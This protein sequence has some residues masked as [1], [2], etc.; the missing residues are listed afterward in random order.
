MALGSTTERMIVASMSNATAIAEAHLLE[1]D[2]V[3]AGEACEHRDDDQCGA[4]DDSSRRR[5]A[6]RHRLGRVAGLVVALSDP[7][8]Q[9]HLVVHREPEEHGE[10]E[11]RHPRLDRVRL[12]EAEQIGADTFLEDEHQQAVRGADREQVERHGR[13]GHHDRPEDDGEQHERQR[14]HERDHPRRGVDDRVEVVDVLRG[15]AADEDLGARPGERL[16][17]DLGAKLAHGRHRIVAGGVALDR[18]GEHGDGAVGGPSDLSLAEPRIGCQAG[19][20][21]GEGSRC[22]RAVGALRDDDLDRVGRRLREVPFEG[23]EALLRREAVGKR[24]DAA[25]SDVHAEDRR[26]EQ[27]QERDRQRQAQPRSAQDAPDDAAPEAALR[28]GGREQPLSDERDPESI[29][30]VPEQ[31]EQR[32]QQRRRSNNRDDPDRDRADGQAPHDRARHEQHPEHGDDERGAAEDHG[33]ARREPRDGDRV[34]LLAPLRALLAVSGDD[35]QGVV[36]PEREPHPRE[37]VDHEDGELEP[38]GE[39]RDEAEGDDDRDARHQNRDEARHDGSEDEQEDDERCRKA[40]LELAGLEI[41]LREQVEV[42]VECLVTGDGDG[43]RC[44]LVGARSGLHDRLGLVVVEDR[45]RDD[46]GVAVGGDERS[47]RG[48]EVRPRPRESRGGALVREAAHEALELGRVDGVALGAHDDDVRERG[49]RVRGER[50]RL[51]VDGALR[52]RIVR[53][54]ALGREAAPEQS[55]D[56]RDRSDGDCDP[57]ADRGPRMAC[58][59]RGERLRR[60]SHSVRP[61]PS[62]LRSVRPVAWGGARI[63]V[64]STPPTLDLGGRSPHRPMGLTCSPSRGGRYCGVAPG[65]TT[66]WS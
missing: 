35:E 42:V 40:E 37:H 56:R 17:R 45:D 24:R 7:A 2:E 50:A 18:D 55:D 25:R 8:E 26:G 46:R 63:A 4:R 32:R 58:A 39:Q 47:G 41:L 44:V 19:P 43:E 29:D 28:V 66:P 30:A 22:D 3:S 38:L 52:L 57:D 14:E 13:A 34:V 31:S 64:V 9:E 5:D 1:H 6:E 11:Q 62:G 59:Q 21:P 10:E 16:R 20:Q 51:D 48:R 23:D 49:L 27:Q 54:L 65:V 53:G 60:E 12:L 15:R 61:P 33:P 36:D